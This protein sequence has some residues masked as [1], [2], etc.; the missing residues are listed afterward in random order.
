[1]NPTV[2]NND[3]TPTEPRPAD[4]GQSNEALRRVRMDAAR[5]AAGQR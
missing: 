2:S 5:R 4:G 3:P 1:M